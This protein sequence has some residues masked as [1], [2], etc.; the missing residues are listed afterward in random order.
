METVPLLSACLIVRDE[1][2]NLGRCLRSLQGLADEVIVVDTGSIDNTVEIALALGAQVFRQEWIGDFSYHRNS[3]IDHATGRWVY[4]IDGDE[5]VVETDFSE[6]RFHLL[7]EELPP[8]LLV[9]E[10]LRYPTRKEVIVAVPRVFRRECGFRYK[11]PIHEQLDAVGSLAAMSNIKVLH[12][13]YESAEALH[14]KETRNLEIAMAMPDSPHAYHCRARAA[15]TVEKWDVVVDSAMALSQCIETPHVAA[16][17]CVLGGSAA[18]RIGDL[19]TARMLAGKA[20]EF[21]P[22]TPDVR[23]LGLLV[24]AEEYLESLKDGDMTTGGTILR[25]PMFWHN[26]QSVRTLVDALLGRVPVR[27]EQSEHVAELNSVASIGVPEGKR[28]LV[29]TTSHEGE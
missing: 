16:E 15:Y 9:R 22:G 2:E 20:A 6:T 4:C 19:E 13:G 7:R 24:A 18:A 1:A 25:A 29:G 11:F 8:V 26:K 14:R 17:A 27:T 23:F 21:L 3:A 12:H 5:E 28:A 10:I